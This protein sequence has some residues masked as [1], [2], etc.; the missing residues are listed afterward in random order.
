MRI[1]I[2]TSSRADFG[3]YSPLLEKLQNDPFFDLEIIAFGTHLSQKHGQTV[4]EIIEKGFPV[5]YRLKTIPEWDQPEKISLSMAKTI[6]LF[7]EFWSKEK[8]DMIFALGD[9]FEMFAAVTAATPFNLDIAHIHAGET[10]LGAIDNAYRH[11]IS[12]FSKYLFTCTEEYKKKAIRI[13]GNPDKVYN[14][15]SLSFDTLKKINFY[16]PEKLKKMFGIDFLKPT[17]LSTFHPET[18]DYTKNDFYI[19]ELIKVW[20]A[21]SG[22]YQIV[23]SPP[24]ADT[25]GNVIREKEKIFAKG[26]GKTFIVESFGVNAY[27]SAMKYAHFLLG[28]SSSAFTEAAFFPKKVINIGRRQ[29]GRIVTPNILNVEIN[30][31]KILKAVQEIEEIPDPP[32]IDLYG[33]GNSADKIVHI[34]KEIYE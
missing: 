17:V 21:L 5:Q 30:H 13:C 33:D 11:S 8:F 25:M 31:K 29:S 27:L 2:L 9:R 12:L 14:V 15:G 22:R 7:S 6:E 10:T 32:K 24:N 3:I 28:N 26:N 1:G 19:D 16:S 18:V 34:L 4:N 20:E 23:I